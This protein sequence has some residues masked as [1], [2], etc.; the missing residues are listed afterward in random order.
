MDPYDY[1]RIICYKCNFVNS[2]GAHGLLLHKKPW[3]RKHVLSVLVYSV[4]TTVTSRHRLILIP[5]VNVAFK[6]VPVST[7]VLMS[8]WDTT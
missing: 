7:F 3:T 8:V 1:F 4:L 5:S 6:S 2:N